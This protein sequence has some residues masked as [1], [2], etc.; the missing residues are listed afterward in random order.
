MPIGPKH[1]L[2]LT[3]IFVFKHASQ[4]VERHHSAVFCAL[5]IED[6]ISSKHFYR[7][8]VLMLLIS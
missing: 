1:S 5:N 6:L 3:G 8:L 2:V 4:F 7:I